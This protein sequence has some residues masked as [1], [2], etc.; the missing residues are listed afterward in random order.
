MNDVFNTHTF[1]FNHRATFELAVVITK[2]L[3]AEVGEDLCDIGH[4][5]MVISVFSAV[6]SDMVKSELSTH[7][8]WDV[9]SFKGG[10]D[11]SIEN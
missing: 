7:Q 2:K 5:D 8:I 6:G 11:F 3:E 9:P 1:R 10:A 4:A